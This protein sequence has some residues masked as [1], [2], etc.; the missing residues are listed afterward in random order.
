[1]EPIGWGPPGGKSAHPHSAG[2]ARA[3]Y[4]LLGAAVMYSQRCSHLFGACRQ[5]E[6]PTKRVHGVPTAPLGDTPAFLALGPD[7]ETARDDD[8]ARGR[9][10]SPALPDDTRQGKRAPR[11]L[12][13]THAE[14]AP[15]K[16]KS[17]PK[18]RSMPTLA[19][20]PIQNG[21]GTARSAVR[22]TLSTR[23]SCPLGITARQRGP[24]HANSRDATVCVR[25]QT[26]EFFYPVSKRGK[27]KVEKRVGLYR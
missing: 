8:V 23:A 11:G 1:M 6:A 24:R 5:A 9:G 27:N 20:R 10:F 16:E 15:S 13:R 18:G 2:F 17:R 7:R 3:L 25:A 19:W 21:R 22:D 26:T 14:A 4:A 12:P